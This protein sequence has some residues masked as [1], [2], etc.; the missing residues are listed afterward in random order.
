VKLTLQHV[1]FQRHDDGSAEL[2][3]DLPSRSITGTVVDEM[4]RPTAPA[5]IDVLFPD[6][7]LQQVVSE[8]GSFILTGLTAGRYR[9][10]AFSKELESVDL[11]DV[12]LSDDKDATSDVVLPVV[13]VGHLRGTIR[14]LDGP[15]LGAALFATRPGDD[16]RPIILSR[17]DPE[18]HFDIRFPAAT[19]EVV[20]AI[21]APGFAFRLTRAPLGKE[22]ETFAVEQNGGTLSIDAPTTKSGLRPYLMH[23][24]AILGAAVVGYVAGAPFQ[25]NLSER[26]RFQIPSVEAGAY[27]LCWLADKRTAP[28][29]AVPPCISGVI[30][31]HGALTLAE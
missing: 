31:P 1:H 13:P 27:S 6:N 10:R 29:T 3:V 7:S 20:V 11:Q 18:G 14:A 28:S 24:G 22:E 16:T 2:N 21:N 4:G 5:M 30:A 12:P 17:V 19:S 23:D 8:D 15:V 26:V 25:A 9:L